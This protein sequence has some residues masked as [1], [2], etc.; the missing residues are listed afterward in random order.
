[1]STNRKAVRIFQI[2]TNKVSPKKNENQEKSV[3]FLWRFGVNIINSIS[4]R[5][6]VARQFFS[7]WVLII[8]VQHSHSKTPSLFWFVFFYERAFMKFLLNLSVCPNRSAAH[9]FFRS[10]CWWANV[11]TRCVKVHLHAQ[12]RIETE[13]KNAHN[14]LIWNR[15]CWLMT[16]GF[17][18]I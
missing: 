3:N 2:N 6:L 15:C 17:I 16:T 14:T 8:S 5:F 13:P 11:I 1:M 9:L 10:F 4:F 12:L 7:G 18:R